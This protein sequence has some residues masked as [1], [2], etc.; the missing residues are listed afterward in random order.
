M[1]IVN[2]VLS[3]NSQ[4][5]GLTLSGGSHFQAMVQGNN[6][7]NNLSGVDVIG[8]GITA[9]VIDLGGGSLG[10]TGGNNF[11]SFTTANDSSYAIGL[12]NVSSGYSMTALENLFSV[13]PTSVIADGHHDLAAGG[14]GNIIV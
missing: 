7:N 1:S 8:D 4:A 5:T 10:S 11:R 13:P 14:S 6:F 2:N 3:T 12:F 9:G